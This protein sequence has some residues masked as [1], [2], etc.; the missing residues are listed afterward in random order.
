MPLNLGALTGGLQSTFAS[1]P[2]DAAGCAAQW[3]D[4]AE[5]WAS[6]LVPASTTVTSAAAVL[7]G[8]LAS[9]FGSPNA[10]PGMESAF[11][12]FGVAVG[13]GMAGFTPVPPAGPVGFASIFGGPAPETH[14]QAASAVAGALD[15]WM[16]TGSATLIAPPFTVVPWS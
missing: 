12:A 2:A 16:K 10:I 7:E 8:Q 11:A 13:L 3:A 4:A 15:A 5:A 9:A 1:P 6:S 14:A